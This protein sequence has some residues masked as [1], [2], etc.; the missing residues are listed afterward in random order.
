MEVYVE[1]KEWRGWWSCEATN[2]SETRKQLVSPEVSTFGLIS[3][4]C[5]EKD[6]L[7]ST[8]ESKSNPAFLCETKYYSHL[9]RK[10]S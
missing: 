5:F 6:A 7:G 8:L 4:P 2:K 3:A 9:N 1:V 10:M